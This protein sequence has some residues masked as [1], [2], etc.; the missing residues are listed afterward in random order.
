MRIPEPVRKRLIQL[1]QLLPALD[2]DVLTSLE[3]SRLTGMTDATVR[4][5]IS[6]VRLR[7]ASNGYKRL[8]LLK[9]VQTLLVPQDEIKK[10]CIIG[11]GLFAQALTESGLLLSSPF[12]VAAGFDS[13]LNR[14]ET[15]RAP[16]PLYPSAR[17]ES[18]IAAENIEYAIITPDEKDAP[19]TANR[20]VQCGIKGIVNY[21]CAVLPP[22]Q[23]TKVENLSLLGSLQNLASRNNF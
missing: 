11:L 7:G 10:C 15:M 16:F 17:L 19:G 2:A 13:S 21:G 20:L 1:A 6:Y 12:A 5:D 23:K 9:A 8:E 14:V 4:K 22:A 18:V 3:L